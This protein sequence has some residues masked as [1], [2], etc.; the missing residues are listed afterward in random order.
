MR[1][2]NLKS[3]H[4][5]RF[6]GMLQ[7]LYAYDPLLCQGLT[8]DEKSATLCGIVWLDNHALTLTAKYYFD[9]KTVFVSPSYIFVMNQG[10]LSLVQKTF[11]FN[12][13][14]V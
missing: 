6:P 13:L 14:C 8:V 9:E 10:N 4:T 5:Q 3:S 12:A 2:L 7:L 11:T 1:S